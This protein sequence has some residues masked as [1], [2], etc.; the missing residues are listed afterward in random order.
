MEIEKLQKNNSDSNSDTNN[1]GTTADINMFD[2]EL[3]IVN[4]QIN[5]HSENIS[6]LNIERL[7]SLIEKEKNALKYSNLTSKKLSLY[8]IKN[9]VQEIQHNLQTFFELPGKK[10]KEKK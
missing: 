9:N 3:H 10:K 5:H 7:T 4:N 2:D 8:E 1:S 6:F